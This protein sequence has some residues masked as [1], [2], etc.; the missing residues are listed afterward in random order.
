MSDQP[1]EHT[2]STPA[3]SPALE[4]AAMPSGVTALTFAEVEKI[5]RALREHGVHLPCPRCGTADFRVE[6]AYF[7][8]SI[9]TS[10]SGISLGGPSIP[11]AVTTCI[12]CGFV[13]EH[14]LGTLG[15]LAAE[16]ST[17]PVKK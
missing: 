11:T 6:P 5:I 13:S 14:A 10:L 9:Q 17:P 8:H 2:E 1:S 3:T 15:L 12:R 16:S 4:P 7:A